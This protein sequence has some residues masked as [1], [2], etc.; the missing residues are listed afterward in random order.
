MSENRKTID[1]LYEEI[2]KMIKEVH[3]KYI[4]TKAEAYNVVL[5]DDYVIVL[6]ENFKMLDG[7]HNALIRVKNKI[8]EL[9]E[10][11]NND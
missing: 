2:D 6:R 5:T 4:K 3:D 8:S 1:I 7:E 9:L 10:E 11:N